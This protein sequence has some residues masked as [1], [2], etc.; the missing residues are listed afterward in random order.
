MIKVIL[1]AIFV[2]GCAFTPLPSSAA[3][4]H[5][6]HAREI[7]STIMSPF[8]PARLLSDC[9]SP[10]ATELKVKILSDLRGGKSKEQVLEELYST[11]GSSVRA[12]PEA[13]GFG[14]LA[15]WI[16]ILFV[17]V[18]GIVFAIWLARRKSV[19][20]QSSSEPA[21]Q[22]SPEMQSRIE[23]ELNNS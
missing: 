15:W 19:E 10:S 3:D 21:N 2:I 14:A 20:V 11:F 4:L 1:S 6:D 22:L 23:K 8:C 13:K 12:A 16:P 18:G 7:Y 9:P 17:V 5:E